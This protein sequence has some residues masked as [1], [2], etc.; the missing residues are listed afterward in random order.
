MGQRSLRGETLERPSVSIKL[1]K[2]E[3]WYGKSGSKWQTMP[4][5]MLRYRAATFFGRLYAPDLLMG[6]QTQE[7]V[8]DVGIESRA[9]RAAVPLPDRCPREDCRSAG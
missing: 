3:G 1:A 8:M 9:K 4:D 5:P 6:M 7:E 2:A